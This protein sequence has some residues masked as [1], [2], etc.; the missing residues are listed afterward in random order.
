MKKSVAIFSILMGAALIGT[1]LVLFL[2]GDVPALASRPL[3]SGLL[4]VVEF[5]TGVSLIVGGAGC[6][7]THGGACQ[8][9]WS[10]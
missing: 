8:L 10:R 6:S 4:L 3:Q 5:L 7:S 2:L 1:W 9:S